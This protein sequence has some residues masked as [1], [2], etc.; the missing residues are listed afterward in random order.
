[1]LLFLIVYYILSFLFL[2]LTC[3]N[4]QFKKYHLISKCLCSI[5]FLLAAILGKIQSSNDALFWRLFPAFIL[6]FLGDYFLAKQE[7]GE[8][9]KIFL[10]GL[11]SFLLGHCTFLFALSYVQPVNRYTFI[12]PLLGVIFVKGLTMLNNMEVGQ[13]KIPVLFYAYFVSALFVKWAQI[14][15]NGERSPFY[16]LIFLGGFLFLLSD[17]IILFLYFY[18]KKYGIMKFLNLFT[19][20]SATFLLGI[21]IIYA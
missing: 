13:Q 10:L 14:A 19:Y 21:S 15:I 11:S 8:Q 1:M 20:Y 6:C 5:G 17:E 9:K 2:M 3:Y 16:V 7:Q 4:L 12:L 18:Q